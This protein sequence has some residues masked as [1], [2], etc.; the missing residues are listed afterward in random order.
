MLNQ[1]SESVA[2]EKMPD[3][4]VNVFL[5]TMLHGS[6]QHLQPFI[7]VC[8]FSKNDNPDC[9]AYVA[10]IFKKVFLSLLFRSIDHEKA[11]NE[12]EIKRRIVSQS[13]N[14][15]VMDVVG[16]WARHNQVR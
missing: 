1:S 10:Q 6:I 7:F 11:Q 9:T 12:R 13:G 4:F 5:M 14:T 16:I 2:K 15:D 8:A 3:Y